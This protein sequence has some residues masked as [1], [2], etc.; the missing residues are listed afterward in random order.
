MMININPQSTNLLL[1]EIKRIAN[2]CDL[3]YIWVIKQFYN[4]KDFLNIYASNGRQGIDFSP[5]HTSNLEKYD[6]EISSLYDKYGL[7]SKIET[8]SYDEY[9]EAYPSFEIKKEVI[10]IKGHYDRMFN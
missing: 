6:N 10:K 7:L 5:Y 9:K 4:N 2:E 1:D 8:I 3:L